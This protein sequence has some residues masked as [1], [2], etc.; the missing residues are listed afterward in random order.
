VL[1]LSLPFTAFAGG[2][3]QMTEANIAGYD[4]CFTGTEYNVRS[5]C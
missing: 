5:L 2:R 1:L 4:V 3:Y